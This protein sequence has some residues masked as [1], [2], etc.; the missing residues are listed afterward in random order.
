MLSRMCCFAGRELEIEVAN[1]QIFARAIAPGVQV[2]AYKLDLTTA[3]DAAMVLPLPVPPGS[4][5]S[6]VRFISVE[7]HAGMFAQLEELFPQ[8]RSLAASR[9]QDLR[10]PVNPAKLVVHDVG[11]FVASYVP[12]RA[13]FDRLD[14]QFRID[15]A[16]FDGVPAY[17][18]YG[19]AVFQLR[20]GNLRVHPMAFA[21]PTR[22]PDRLFFP[23]V[24]LHDGTLHRTAHF[25]HV[26]YYQHPA[27]RRSMTSIFGD[28][29]SRFGAPRIEDLT[30]FGE[31]VARRRLHGTLPNQD[32]WI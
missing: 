22:A 19:F 5:E 21:F 26:L 15:D 14:P 1:T 25:D 6:A 20:A 9:L 2:L 10:G 3:R 4:P 32:T 30:E 24:H 7:H 11:A 13:D 23:T 27:C 28:E 31:L 12:S 17:R 18:D 8:M 29:V 16:L